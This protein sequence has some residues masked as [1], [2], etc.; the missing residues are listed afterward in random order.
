MWWMHN[1]ISYIRILIIESNTKIAIFDFV[2]MLIWN[3]KYEE[4][5]KKKEI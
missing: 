5:T 3:K 1:S 2:N 4:V